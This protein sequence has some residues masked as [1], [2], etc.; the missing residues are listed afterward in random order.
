MLANDHGLVVCLLNKWELEGREIAS[1]RSRGRLVWSLAGARSLDEI[2]G[3]LCGLPHYQAFTLAVFSPV[4]E[5][6]W[7][8]TG[9]ELRRG[10]MPEMLT[11]SSFRFQDV[12]EA[13][14]ACFA[15]GLR[16]EEF[17]CSR[18]EAPSPY[19]V[20]MNR[21]D[22]QTWSRSRVV[23]GERISWQYWAEPA[24]LKGEARET[25]ME[26]SLS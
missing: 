8:W 9:E 22:A 14:R 21:P 26:L 15:S 16:G 2:A 10:E 24:D 17:H 5:A 18:H 20:R 7:E 23:V 13:R 25:V 1:P 6:C 19:S 12:R 4:G 11:S 3:G